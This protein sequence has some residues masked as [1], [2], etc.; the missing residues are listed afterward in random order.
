ME[1]M[2]KRNLKESKVR[3]EQSFAFPEFYTQRLQVEQS[4]MNL[5]RLGKAILEA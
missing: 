2:A 1:F 5:R 4:Q 3:I